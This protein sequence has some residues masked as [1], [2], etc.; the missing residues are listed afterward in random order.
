MIKQISESRHCN[1][2]PT[3]FDTRSSKYLLIVCKLEKITLKYGSKLA[4]YYFI[5]LK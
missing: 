4:S 1:A 3:V 2:W 5:L